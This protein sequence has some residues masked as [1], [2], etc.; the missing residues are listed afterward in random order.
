M[1]L[2][3]IIYTTHIILTYMCVI[4]VYGVVVSVSCFFLLNQ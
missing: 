1:M 2:D 4:Y 3:I